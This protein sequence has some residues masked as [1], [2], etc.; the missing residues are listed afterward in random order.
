MNEKNRFHKG[1]IC[2]DCGGSGKAIEK[3]LILKNNMIISNEVN[4]KKCGGRG[5]IKNR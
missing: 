1:I 2:L 3:K 4:C 5:W